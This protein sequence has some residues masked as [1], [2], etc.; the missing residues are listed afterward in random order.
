MGRLTVRLPQT[1]H[2]QLMML[3]E[4]EG[5]SLNQYILY[6]LTRQV[7]P[8]YVV[9]PV[10]SKSA[11]EQEEQ[12]RATLQ[13]LGNITDAEAQTILA[14]RARVEPEEGLTPELIA[15]VQALI[16]AAHTGQDA[17]ATAS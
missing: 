10:V 2:Q 11:V 15:R 14:K 4:Q 3:A 8:G 5:V 17:L 6:S 16:D 9:Q 13:R 12:F 1:L 7:T